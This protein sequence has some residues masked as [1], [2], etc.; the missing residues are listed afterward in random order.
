MERRLNS[1]SAQM[2]EVQDILTIRCGNT[3]TPMTSDLGEASTPDQDSSAS[4]PM[5]SRQDRPSTLNRSVDLVAIAS[6][7]GG[8]QAVEGAWVDVYFQWDA[9]ISVKREE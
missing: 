7:S 6:T 2:A 3:S 1:L 8:A 4:W 9:L 5:R